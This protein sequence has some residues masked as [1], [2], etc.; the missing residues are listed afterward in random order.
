MTD[1]IAKTLPGRLTGAGLVRPR[2]AIHRPDFQP[3]G[4]GAAILKL[5]QIVAAAYALAYA[6]PFGLRHVHPQRSRETED[7]RRDPNW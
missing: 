1:L 7:D 4:I 5:A 6:A 2:R 3:L